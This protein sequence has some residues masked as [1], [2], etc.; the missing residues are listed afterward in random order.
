MAIGNGRIDGG[1]TIISQADGRGSLDTIIYQADTDG[2]GSLCWR[3][4]ID[5]THGT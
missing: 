1:D 3:N 5:T 4:S 2:R